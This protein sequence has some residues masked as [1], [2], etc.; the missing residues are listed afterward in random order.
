MRRIHGIVVSACALACFVA[1]PT[2]AQ[3]LGYKLLGSAG[4][5]AGVQSPP[6]LFVLNRALHFG[7]DEVRD[8]HGNVVPISGLNIDAFGNSLGAAYTLQT[9]HRQYLTFALGLPVARLRV[10][11]DRPEASINGQGFSD[12]FLQPLKLGWRERQFDVVTAYMIYV[13]TGKFEPRKGSV[14]RGY[15]THQFSLGG[16]AYFDSTRTSRASALI[17]YDLNT[18]KRDIDIRKGN[19]VQVQGGAGIGVAKVAVVG[20]AGYAFWQ[21]TRDR[22]A[23]I[24]PAL[25]HEWARTY[26]LGPEIDLTIPRLRMRADFRI[27]REM[28]VRS[29]PKGQVIALGVSYA[30]WRPH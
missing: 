22:G 2:T 4:I 9:R 19:S 8:R 16:A 17:S 1:R 5:D 7:S 23:D 10:N 11:S 3:Q 12:M 26:A 20:I 24:P 30:A 6:G 25:R 29:R 21:T 28:G 13:P 15:W 14:G 27:E 18:R